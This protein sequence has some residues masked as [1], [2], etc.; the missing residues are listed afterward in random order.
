MGAGEDNCKKSTS[1]GEDHSKLLTENEHKKL[2]GMLKDIKSVLDS[3]P[4]STEEPLPN[5]N[6]SSQAKNDLPE[7]IEQQVETFNS[8]VKEAYNLSQKIGEQIGDFNT[9]IENFSKSIDDK[10][11]EL[12][13]ATEKFSETV[14]NI[15]ELNSW[16]EMFDTFAKN[17]KTFKETT[18]HQNTVELEQ[19]KA[20]KQRLE[21]D[22]ESVRGELRTKTTE[23]GDKQRELDSVR[24]QLQTKTA[25][26]D[27]KQRELE[28]VRGELQ[29][30]TADLDA[31]QRELESVRGELRT[32]TTELGDKQ[33]ELENVHGEL[34]TKTAELGD[35]QRELD[36]FRGE[37]KKFEA[38]AAQANESVQSV[39]N[40]FNAYEPVLA[41]LKNCPLFSEY[42]NEHD[43][44]AGDSKALFRLARKMGE[45]SD[46]AS[47]IH[48]IAVEAKKNSKEPMTAAEG[49]VYKAISRCYAEIWNIDFD[50]FICPGEQ[51][52]DKPY[53]TTNFNRSDMINL[54]DPRD[55]VS[56][57]AQEVYVP[58]LRTKN[59]GLISQARV[60]AGNDMK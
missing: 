44:T 41:A 32:K 58:L 52:T 35:K 29:T 7:R 60:K 48:S 14:K 55:K 33:R 37:V 6:E 56:K 8:S 19:L 9:A 40:I 31:K 2:F 34:R 13:C 26:F 12:N 38:Q 59:R 51:S 4:K 53:T 18:E 28:S 23:L 1:V 47:E 21:G 15:G 43:L 27:A 39:K 16:Q 17:V 46:F 24:G 36:S 49:I 54:L 3:L 30:K 45:T 22:L 57:Y 20:D 42:V 50:I 5:T 11:Q 25:D 10:T